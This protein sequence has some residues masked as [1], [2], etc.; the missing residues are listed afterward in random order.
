MTFTPPEDGE[1]ML[2]I[3]LFDMHFPQFD[4]R[5]TFNRISGILLQQKWEQVYVI[6]GQD[7]FHNDDMRG[8]TSKGTRINKVDMALAWRMARSFWHG[9]ISLALVQAKQVHL[10][11]SKGNHDE[12]LAWA[13]VQSL[14]EAFPQVDVDDSLQ[15]RKV[16]SWER[17]FVGI[18]HGDY[19]M[20][21]N[22]D[23]RGQFSIQ[24]PA[25]FAAASVREIHAGHLH[26]EKSADIYGVMCRRLSHV[27]GADE[28]ADDEGFIG[29]H[30]RFM[31]F[32]YEPDRLKSIIYV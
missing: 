5:E 26:H 11:Y 20:N 9:I 28:W 7:L 30:A 13:F 12:S 32:A 6:I 1:D 18:T 29:A 17:V 19:R 15:Q 16:I 23:L 31:L 10:L 14:K 24:F 2:E 25:Q 3:P 22:S 27:G 4:H 8:H 21:K